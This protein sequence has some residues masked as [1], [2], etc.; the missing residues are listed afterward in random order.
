MED[1][2]KC[3]ILNIVQDDLIS[4]VK[5]IFRFQAKTVN[6]MRDPRQ[7][8]LKAIQCAISVKFGQELE[9]R[10]RGFENFIGADFVKY[11]MIYMTDDV[12]EAWVNYFQGQLQLPKSC[13]YIHRIRDG[14]NGDDVPFEI[15]K[16]YEQI[17]KDHEDPTKEPVIIIGT[18]GTEGGLDDKVNLRF[19]LLI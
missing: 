19:Y 6:G 1:E 15:N 16:L 18:A 5:N 10:E 17:T 9:Q 2:F 14:L 12:P 4:W 7:P 11:P 13:F 3:E 8:I